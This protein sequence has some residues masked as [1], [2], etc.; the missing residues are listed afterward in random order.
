MNAKTFEIL[1][2]SS[3]GM[4]CSESTGSI[5]KLHVMHI[6]RFIL[7]TLRRFKHLY[8]K[9]GQMT[10]LLL[11]QRPWCLRQ[12]PSYREGR[13][14]LAG[15]LQH[16]TDCLVWWRCSTVCRIALTICRIDTYVRSAA[17]LGTKAE[18]VALF[19]PH[20]LMLYLTKFTVGLPSLNRLNGDMA[21]WRPPLVAVRRHVIY[22]WALSG[23]I[24][25]R[26]II[27]NFR[28]TLP[29]YPFITPT[30]Y[31]ISNTRTYQW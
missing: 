19:G 2:R 9:P 11:K 25:R 23:E 18:Q 6:I 28:H 22:T 12:Q 30:K 31:T 29:S 16:T 1:Q 3:A 10:F 14:K 21:L 15:T 17:V 8:L 24:R 27:F 4:S 13:T 5:C 7:Y 26:V 20:C